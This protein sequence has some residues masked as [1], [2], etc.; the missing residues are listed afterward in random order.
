MGGGFCEGL[1]PPNQLGTGDRS[2]KNSPLV[3][4]MEVGKRLEC[5]RTTQIPN[6]VIIPAMEVM[7]WNQPNTENERIRSFGS[8]IFTGGSEP[9]LFLDRY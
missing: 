5:T 9:N 8:T 7:F 2:V 6:Q 1:V 3:T 4:H